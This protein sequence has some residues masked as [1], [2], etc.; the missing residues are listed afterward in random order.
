MD[1]DLLSKNAPPGFR[2]VGWRRIVALSTCIALLLASWAYGFLA[3]PRGFTSGNPIASFTIEPDGSINVSGDTL[4][5]ANGGR[6]GVSLICMY[7]QSDPPAVRRGFF[8]LIR[9]GARAPATETRIGAALEIRGPRTWQP[10][11]PATFDA[12]REAV[13]V[14][15]ERN[16]IGLDGEWIGGQKRSSLLEPLP[17]IDLADAIRATPSIT[18]APL[19]SSPLTNVVA[20]RTLRLGVVALGVQ[21]AMP[22]V[23]LVL[24]IPIV[25][26]VWRWLATPTRPDLSRCSVCRYSLR[27]LKSSVCPECGSAVRRPRRPNAATAETN[28]DAPAPDV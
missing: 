12:V 23:I 20:S 5:S 6:G 26:S 9:L 11:S 27:G 3:R 21:F 4:I 1:A 25:A 19:N 16:R 18:V 15:F 14:Y 7:D 8:A 17:T 24:A 13:A 22:P 28:A 2:P 10:V